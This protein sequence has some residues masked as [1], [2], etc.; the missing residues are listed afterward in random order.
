M[1]GR[2]DAALRMATVTDEDLGG[3]YLQGTRPSPNDNYGGMLLQ[4]YL[5]ER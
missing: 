3:I 1:T 5:E 2:I 4:V